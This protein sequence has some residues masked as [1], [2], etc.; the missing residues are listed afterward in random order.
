MRV[1]LLIEI[2]K[3]IHLNDLPA[4]SEPT[5]YQGAF[6]KKPEQTEKKLPFYKS[7]RFQYLA[8]TASIG[9]CT[10]LTYVAMLGPKRPPDMGE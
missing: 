1:R 8:T 5:L 3:P 6:M 4:S 9:L 7:T 10:T 2:Y